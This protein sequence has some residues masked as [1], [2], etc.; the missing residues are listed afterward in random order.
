MGAVNQVWLRLQS[1]TKIQKTMAYA[2]SLQQ[3]GQIVGYFWLTKKSAKVTRNPHKRCGTFSTCYEAFCTLV[4]DARLQQV[5]ESEFSRL[6]G[7][8]KKIVEV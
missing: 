7:Y 6:C 3:K 4:F 1:L 8:K 2:I 5:Y